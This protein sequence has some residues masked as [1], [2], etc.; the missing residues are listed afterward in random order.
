MVKSGSLLGLWLSKIFWNL[1]ELHFY[2]K[3]FY[4]HKTNTPNKSIYCFAFLKE[5]I[6]MWTTTGLPLSLT[7]ITLEA[8]VLK[9][10]YNKNTVGMKQ[11]GKVSNCTELLQ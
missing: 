3:T 10:E 6:F 2:F 7:G 11:K 4:V 9:E 8:N 5:A 1:A